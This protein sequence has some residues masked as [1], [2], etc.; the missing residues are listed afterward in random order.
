MQNNQ[1]FTEFTKEDAIR[2][3]DC[4]KAM[5]GGLAKAQGGLMEYN[6]A[7]DEYDAI[8]NRYSFEEDQIDDLVGAVYAGIVGPAKEAAKNDV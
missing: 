3:H 8:K 1:G 6:R 5:A 4:L 7:K 2:L